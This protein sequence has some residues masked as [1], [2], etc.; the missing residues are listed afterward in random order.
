M[1]ANLIPCLLILSVHYFSYFSFCMGISLCGGKGGW[2]SS[3]VFV[4]VDFL[5]FYLFVCLILFF[6]EMCKC[7]FYVIIS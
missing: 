1:G 5:I 7:V 4:V 6:Q 3:V 2:V